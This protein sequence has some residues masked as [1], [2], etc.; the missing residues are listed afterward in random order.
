LKKWIIFFLIALLSV[1]AFSFDLSFY[2][3]FETLT[4]GETFTGISDDINAVYY[5]PA[6][7]TNGKGFVFV[8]PSM[9][10]NMSYGIGSSLFK[11][12]T[13]INEIESVLA[14]TNTANVVSY[15]LKN[16]GQDLLNTNRI[17][18]KTNG[19]IGYNAKNFAFDIS[20]FAQGYAR[21]FVS[22]DLVPFV[23]LHAKAAAYLEGTGA[24]AFDISSVKFSIG[25]TYRYGYVMPNIYSVDNLSVLSASSSTFEPNLTY[26]A[27]SNVDLGVKISVGPFNFGGLWHNVT[28]SSTPNLRI[29]TGF[30]TRNLAIGV[31]F[32]KLLDS[33]YSFFRR[34]HV[35]I[36]YVP[37]DFVKLYGGLSAGWFVGGAELELGA[38][39]VYGGTYV[40]NGGFHAG[41]DY[42]RMYIIGF[43][44]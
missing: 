18:V 22:N 34:L 27:T 38:V 20:G 36:R 29:G 33:H 17:V 35:G 42:Q 1:M 9:N 12:L 5:N 21:T 37:F 15:F 7:L 41:Y 8:F 25:G 30:V 26:K 3:S 44:L 10:I 31:D 11:A 19:Y 24:L 2:N 6:G 40:I 39:K 32:E 23:S 14:S 43:G 13:H 28:N 4:M 16:Y